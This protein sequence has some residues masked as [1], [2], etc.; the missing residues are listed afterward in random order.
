[1]DDPDLLAELR[2]GI[3]N[4]RARIVRADAGVEPWRN[5]DEEVIA[6]F[7]A[8]WGEGILERI[9]DGRTTLAELA[10]RRAQVERALRLLSKGA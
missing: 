4:A 8:S 2:E 10:E 3:S 1:M 5:I 9:A 6:R 7:V